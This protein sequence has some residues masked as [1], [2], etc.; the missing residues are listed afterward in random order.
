MKDMIKSLLTK[1]IVL[2]KVNPID[3]TLLKT[4]KKIAVF[5]GVDTNSNYVC[6]FVVKRKSRFLRKDVKEL[7]ELFSRLVALSDHNFKKKIL[8]YNMP[9]CSHAKE[10]LKELKWTLIS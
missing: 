8:I 1:K 9:L 2:K 4:R 7:E 5:S 3:T 10:M 6:V